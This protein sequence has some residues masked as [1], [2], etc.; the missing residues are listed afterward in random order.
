MSD[1]K[2]WFNKQIAIQFPAGHDNAWYQL[3]PDMFASLEESAQR[4]IE[5]V[6]RKRSDC[7]KISVKVVSQSGNRH[8][9]VS[10]MMSS[11]PAVLNTFERAAKQYCLDCLT[12]MLSLARR[13][14]KLSEGQMQNCKTTPPSQRSTH[15]EASH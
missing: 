15:A 4:R 5:D 2:V 1:N 9:S 7:G 13:L 3:S 6:M 10:A 11:D 14:A 12:M 8:V